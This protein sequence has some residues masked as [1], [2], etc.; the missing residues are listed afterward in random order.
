MFQLLKSFYIISIIATFFL[1]LVVYLIGLEFVV[2]DSGS[3]I[4][5]SEQP[6]PLL[7]DTL[8]K[9]N[10][11]DE[12]DIRTGTPTKVTVKLDMPSDIPLILVYYYFEGVVL[13][14][15]TID[16]YVLY[17]TYDSFGVSRSKEGLVTLP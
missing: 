11:S 3:S 8:E 13:A 6:G 10:D 14:H 16:T 9:R 2:L 5:M 1:A 15:V 12:Y 4:I 17:Y 7:W